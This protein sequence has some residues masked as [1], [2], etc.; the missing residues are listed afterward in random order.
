MNRMHNSNYPSGNLRTFLTSKATINIE[1]SPGDTFP[2]LNLSR[3]S[4]SSIHHAS[5]TQRSAGDSL[6]LGLNK[7]NLRSSSPKNLHKVKEKLRK[8]T[9]MQK[10]IIKTLESQSSMAT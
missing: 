10:K 1:S 8:T 9:A 5:M 7:S 4:N 2:K 6:R 3:I